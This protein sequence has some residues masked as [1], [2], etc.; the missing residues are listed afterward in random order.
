VRI[1]LDLDA[2]GVE[3]VEELKRLTG[4]RTYKEL[5]NNAI[6][7]FDWAVQQHIQGRK[8]TSVDAKYE[9]CRELIMPALEHSALISGK[10]AG[11]VKD[12]TEEGVLSHS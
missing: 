1:Q 8:V 5:F 7:L 4:S 6:S 2:P 3:L 11:Y 12:A 10:D 9:N